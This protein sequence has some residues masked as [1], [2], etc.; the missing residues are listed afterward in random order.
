MT[1][2]KESICK[3]YERL[4]TEKILLIKDIW[5]IEYELE[6]IKEKIKKYGLQKNMGLVEKT[7]TDG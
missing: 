3:E 1:K 7:E 2:F 6:K 4:T 5:R